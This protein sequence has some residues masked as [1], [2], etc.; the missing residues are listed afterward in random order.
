VGDTGT[1]PKKKVEFLKFDSWIRNGR[2]EAKST[3]E[4]SGPKT[5]PIEYL[6]EGMTNVRELLQQLLNGNVSIDDAETMLRDFSPSIAD[7]GFAQLDLDRS[8]RCGFPEVILAEG[9]TVE[10]VELA[11][12]KLV[13][14]G[15]DCLVTRLDAAQTTRLEQLYPQ[16]A[17]D[18]LARTFLHAKPISATS[19][20]ISIV[21]AGTGDLPI[22]QE[23]KVTA[24]ALG[25]KTR[26][27]TDAGVAGLHR[28]VRRIP[29]L[30]AADVIIVL[31]GMDGALPSVVGGLVDVPVIAVPTSIGYGTSFGGLAAML[32]ML[33]ACSANVS[34]VNIDAG[35]KAGYIAALIARNA[36]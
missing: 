32:T 13:E 14:L 8:K 31:A 6:G 5:D 7:L 21:T 24:E 16:A 23:A 2:L 36:K 22:A 15:Q 18:R 4:R 11:V 35:F 25:A 12:A 10:W 9:K 20:L 1:S 29:E 33:N 19:G 17:S 30:R 26:Q 27:I 28:I 34:V 3:E